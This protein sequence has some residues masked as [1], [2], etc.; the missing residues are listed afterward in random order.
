MEIAAHLLTH[1]DEPAR[2]VCVV[3]TGLV[4]ADGG[5]GYD[6]HAVQCLPTL[7]NFT[8]IFRSLAAVVNAPGESDPGK[9]NLDDT[10]VLINTEFGRTPGVQDGSGGRNHHPYG[11]CT[12]VLGGPITSPSIVGAINER[13]EAPQFS[14]PAESRMA[15]L[16]AMGIYPFS[17]DSFFVSDVPQAQTE[18]D[19]VARVTRSF[20]GQEGT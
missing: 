19:V 3:D 10:L 17:G 8:N 7:T 12:A 5:G 20:L 15:A 11:Y 1:P 4:P 6:T 18:E 16:L 9:L 13:G 14:V 2:Y